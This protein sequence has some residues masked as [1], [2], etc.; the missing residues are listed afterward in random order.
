MTETLER[1]AGVPA[2]APAVVRAASEGDAEAIHRVH[3]ESIRELCSARYAPREIA[4]W[5]AVRSPTSYRVALASRALYVAERE[6]EIVGFGQLDPEKSEIEACYVAPAAIG[7][8]V[9]AALLA[10]MEADAV[11]RGHAVVRLNSTLNAEGFYVRR[12][13]RR[14]G[15]AT[16]RVSGKVD[17]A[18]M[19][20][21]KSLA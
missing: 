21:E 19:R 5:V 1:K 3:S 16:H 15:K 14:L 17:L 6:G 2:A 18:C 12:G 13:Y 11:R 4:A 8:G 10:A 20:M 7:S 9:G